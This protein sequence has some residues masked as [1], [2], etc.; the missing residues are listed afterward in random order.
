MASIDKTYTNS[1]KDY[2]EFKDW[3]DKQIITFFDG[4]E[5]CIGDWVYKYPEEYFDGTEI[6]IM[7]TPTWIDAYLI[8]NCEIPFVI[9]RMKE[10]YDEESYNDLKHSKIGSI[11]SKYKQNRKIII[12][13]SDKCKFPFKKKMFRYPAKK[14][15][16]W[17]L[18]CNDNFWFNDETNKWVH[19]DMLYPNNTNTAHIKSTKALI[20]H[21]RKQYLPSGITFQISGRYIGEN[22]KIIIK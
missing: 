5:K 20:R 15:W 22:Y 3:A 14:G 17:W 7:N 8:Q 13:S 1:Y 12:K 11:P 2:K 19:W 18:Q 6:A 21:L 4:L 16:Y 10:I 9:N